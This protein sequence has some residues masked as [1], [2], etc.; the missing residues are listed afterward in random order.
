MKKSIIDKYNVPGPRYTSYPTVPFWKNDTL[1]VDD[2]LK[3]IKQNHE[4]FGTDDVSV[5]IHLPYCESL[6]TFCG[7]HKRITKN[8][9]VE[10]P[11]IDAILKEWQ[12]YPQCY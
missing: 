8:L 4:H 11:Y 7:C 6:C 5:Y 1:R 3:T 10:T 12:L 2:W 9:A